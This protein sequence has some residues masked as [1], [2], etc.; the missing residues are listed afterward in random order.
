MD[1]DGNDN[2]NITIRAQRT[3][4]T[5]DRHTIKADHTIFTSHKLLLNSEIDDAPTA[6]IRFDEIEW[7]PDTSNGR[8]GSGNAS[9]KFKQDGTTKT[10]IQQSEITQAFDEILWKYFD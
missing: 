9:L 2:I 4:Y 1:H 3:I 10:T 5:T 7:S 8:H 6:T